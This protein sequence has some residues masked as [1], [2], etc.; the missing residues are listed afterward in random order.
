MQGKVSTVAAVKE[1]VWD[2]ETVRRRCETDGVTW[3]RRNSEWRH[4]LP[5]FP[6]TQGDSPSRDELLCQLSPLDS[7][8]RWLTLRGKKGSRDG[9][10]GGEMRTQVAGVVCDARGGRC[11]WNVWWERELREGG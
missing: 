3:G 2:G 7:D 11:G 10:E 4:P 9:M 5:C 8:P 6:V 1:R